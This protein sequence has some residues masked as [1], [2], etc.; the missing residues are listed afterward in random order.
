MWLFLELGVEKSFFSFKM[1]MTWGK[2]LVLFV[3]VLLLAPSFPTLSKCSF[4]C[5]L[6][7]TRDHF[8]RPQR[9]AAHRA[10]KW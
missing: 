1:F 10:F 5:R 8:F 2:A 4:I 9:K 3:S 7:A 6:L